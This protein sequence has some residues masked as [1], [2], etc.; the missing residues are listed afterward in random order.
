MNG[1]IDRVFIDWSQPALP[2]AVEW[3]LGKLASGRAVNLS[4]W[5]V[6]LPTSRSRRRFLQ[7]LASACVGKRLLL[8]P[9]QVITV[10][11]LPELLYQAELP[12]ASD[13]ECRMAWMAAMD[14]LAKNQIAGLVP[15]GLSGN[16]AALEQM[17]ESLQG[18]HVQLG[19]E[20]RS[21][22]SVAD[23]VNKL[24]GFTDTARWNALAEVQRRYYA[25]LTQSGMWDRQAARNV[26]A[27]RGE[28]RADR[29]I[30]LVG[31]ADLN[32]LI[33]KMLGQDAVR[34]RVTSLAF[35]GPK[36]QSGFDEFGSLITD[37]WATA[38]LPLEN[39]AIRFVDRPLDQA[40]GVEYLLAQLPNGMATDE[41]TVCTPDEDVAVHT[42]RL[43]ESQGIATRRLVGTRLS[44]S[45]VARLVEAVVGWLQRQD[46]DSLATL[47]R[48]PDFF[49]AVTEK[50]GN[51]SWLTDLDVF[52]NKYL[53]GL[54]SLKTFS[55]ASRNRDDDYRNAAAVFRVME[56]LLKPMVDWN[57]RGSGSG[58]RGKSKPDGPTA[59]KL[60]VAWGKVLENV[61]GSRSFSGSELNDR[62][63]IESLQLVSDGLEQ[64][65]TLGGD[66]HLLLDLE[67]VGDL[68]LDWLE[69][70]A[71]S[72]DDD[73]AAIE[74][75]GWLDL[76][77]DDARA[78][79]VTGFNEHNI[80]GSQAAHPLLPNRLCQQLGLLDANRRHA[81]DAWIL[82]M[83]VSARE[84]AWLVCGRR[85]SQ[86]SPR[87]PSRLLFATD[88]ETVRIR[89]NAF[90]G[91]QG[92]T[93]PRRWMTASRP[94]A[95][96]Q[97]IAVPKPRPIVVEE[98]ISVTR[99][100]EYLKCPYRFYLS[101]MMGLE[102]VSD[103]VREMD[104]GSFG[105]L[106]HDVLEDFG[107]SEIANSSDVT[108]IESFLVD[109]LKQKFRGMFPLGALPAA[110]MQ[111]ANLEKRLRQFATLQSARRLDG[112]QIVKVEPKVTL[113]FLVD[114]KPF[115]IVGKIDRVDRHD[116]G[117]LA[118]WDYK[119]SDSAKTAMAAHQAKKS[120]EWLDFQLPLYRHLVT[121]VLDDAGSQLD[122]MG[123]GYVLLPRDIKQIAFDSAEW[124]PDQL[125]EADEQVRG[126]LRNIRA[127]NFWPKEADAPEFSDAFAAICQDNALEKW[128]DTGAI[129]GQQ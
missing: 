55:R 78:M 59:G 61:Y 40:R 69:S 45:S 80:P 104:G 107:N 124:T 48:H 42:R 77:L 83:V 72:E 38:R 28:C 16:V 43:I 108:V 63:S 111:V 84:H 121:E 37:W 50:L 32:P 117:R 98:R 10:G 70:Q 68:I 19:T 34:S 88:D 20:G 89:A 127:Q 91:F 27:R 41:I 76:A 15:E 13:L 30:L 49:L 86:N 112:W 102:Q 22:Q 4:Q 96:V 103:D 23:E 120:G 101:A 7:L 106:T 73:P 18:L 56:G 129:H 74:L 44:A 51:E 125:L 53:P 9:G 115:S 25:L 21:F 94:P 39:R 93:V 1:A 64:V 31:I 46:F 36:Y 82:A 26:A 123:L 12:I 67:T 95:R 92:S 11:Q 35:C 81:R 118:V 24:D 58:G 62:K 119:T 79:I 5:T 65:A 57:G 114:G 60:A 116:D 8:E 29:R 71:V 110:E 128:T 33:K 75:A 3:V 6:V 99:L 105:S 109:A 47:A 113:P 14:G 100:R 52:Q 2:A 126:V 97:Q 85:D 17:A 122:S 90:F 66:W 54:L 87:L